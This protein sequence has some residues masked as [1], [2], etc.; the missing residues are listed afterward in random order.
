M[1]E[2]M[3]S[4]NGVADCGA[5]PSFETSEAA[6]DAALLRE[7]YR[8]L[9][10][11]GPYVHGVVILVA[12]ALFGATARAGSLIIGT[13]LPAAL[14]A[15][16][17]YRLGSLFKAR[18]R[19]ELDALDLV[20]RRVRAARLLGP[21]L[22]F[23]FAMTTAIATWKD[24][25][26]EFTLALLT[27]WG[28]A[29]VCAF[30]LNVMAN[31]ASIIVVAATVPLLV[32]FLARGAEL[33]VALAMLVA[34][35]ACFVI[36]MLEENFRMFAEIVRSRFVI[37]EKQRIAEEAQKAA[38]TIALTD[39][40]TGLPNRRCFQTLLAD[41]MM[42]GTEPAKPFALGLIDLDG[43][44]PIND[45]HGHPVGDEILRQ[46]ANRLAKAMDGRGSAIRMGGDEFAILCDGIET[47]DGAI[48]LGERMQAIFAT[49]FAVQ[50]LSIPL[51]SAC[52]FALFPSSAVE[53]SELVRLADAALY[54]A[55]EIG[56]GNVAVFDSRAARSAAC[57][58]AIKSAFRGAL[59]SNGVSSRPFVAFTA[60][61]I[62]TL[63]QPKN[64]PAPSLMP[65][66]PPAFI[67]VPE[68]I[69]VIG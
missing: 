69:R 38:M 3:M 21:A 36:R 63:E 46:V 59:E 13:F 49:P 39:D 4:F 67:R 53:P 37:A 29:A 23:A 34:I 14:I 41:S 5:T 17:V 24:G 65:I 19:V 51:T 35:A 61:R 57:G 45:A 68:R 55:K 30:C 9:A 25:L 43:F 48:A 20:Q 15:V 52:G 6:F 22:T 16:S 28:V 26:L 31:E 56:P 42:S 44:K 66:A 18:E 2:R 1:A 7:Q 27:V 50:L 12:L 62:R 32:A 8:S 40:L 54:R 10:R 11:L 60:G 47:R 58:T 64:M 33:T